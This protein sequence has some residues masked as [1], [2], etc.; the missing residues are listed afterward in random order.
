MRSGFHDNRQIWPRYI[1]NMRFLA[2]SVRGSDLQNGGKL[3]LYEAAGQAAIERMLRIYFLQQWFNLSD[4][5]C[6]RN[7]LATAPCLRPSSRASPKKRWSTRS[8][9]PERNAS[10]SRSGALQR[11]TRLCAGHYRRGNVT[12]VFRGSSAGSARGADPTRARRIARVG[13]RRD[14]SSRG[15][16]AGTRRGNGAQLCH[17]HSL[18]ALAD[19]A[20]A[21]FTRKWKIISVRDQLRTLVPRECLRTRDQESLRA[22]LG[23]TCRKRD[24]P[25]DHKP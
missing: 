2:V 13:N 18:P 21:S 24:I 3:L 23:W 8:N 19:V 15:R 1:S 11:G 6:R 20:H 12:L 10:A 9:I 7:E 5:R 4:P 25:A 14:D 22:L 17:A 16:T